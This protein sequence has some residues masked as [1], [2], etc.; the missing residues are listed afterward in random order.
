MDFIYTQEWGELKKKDGNFIGNIKI[1]TKR[2][3]SI[4]VLVLKITY[5]PGKS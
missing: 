2:T 3:P 1:D 4:I 5:F